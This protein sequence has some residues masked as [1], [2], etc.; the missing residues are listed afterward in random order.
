MSETPAGASHPLRAALWM[1]GAILS[2]STM[3]VAGRAVQVELD[4]FELMT[5]RS[6]VGIAIVCAVATVTGRWHEVRA[7]RM[8]LHTLR[9]LSHF[10]GQNL[11][12]YALMVL[13]MAQVVAIEFSSPI[14]VVLA[15]P[16]L[17][18]ERLTLAKA[19]A[20]LLGFIGVLI[21]AQ[22]DFTR[23]DPALL[24]AALAAMGFAGSLVFTKIL[25]RTESTISIMFWLTV[26]QSVFG[27]VIAGW[28]LDIAIPSA[29]VAPWL[30]LI[31]IAGLAAHFCLTSALTLAPAT[32]VIPI[33]FLRLPVIALIGAAVYGEKLVPAVAIGAVLTF[34][35]N[36]LNTLAEARAR[37]RPLLD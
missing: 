17:L 9:N 36:Y 18:G 8:G 30:V 1:G 2:F 11:W 6:L 34:A 24:A 16:F 3:A 23:L 31:G 4:T 10:A 25:T 29:A 35:A 32:V 21:A 19:G 37:R 22:P 7:R 33:D 20:T 12:F 28:D 14:W 13:P 27:L 5:F 15:A 26:M